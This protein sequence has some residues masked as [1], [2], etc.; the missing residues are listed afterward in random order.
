MKS[1]CVL[2]TML[3]VSL[4]AFTLPGSDRAFGKPLVPVLMPMPGPMPVPPPVVVAPPPVVPPGPVVAP[5]P[6]PGPGPTPTAVSHGGHGAR[7]GA[8]VVGGVIACAGGIIFAA[9]VAS[10]RENRELTHFEA[11]TC[12]L[13]FLFAAPVERRRAVVVRAR[14]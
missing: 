5:V 7:V 3:A 11:F 1:K 13:G 9:I 6:K 12:G 8:A 14:Y 10:A 2:A 4:G